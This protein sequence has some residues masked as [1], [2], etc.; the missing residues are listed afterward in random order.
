[1]QPHYNTTFT[2]MNINLNSRVSSRDFI[3]YVSSWVNSLP[4]SLFK[5]YSL[6]RHQKISDRLLVII[7]IFAFYHNIRYVKLLN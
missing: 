4:D 5:P 3:Y 2:E 6:G 1:M 7:V